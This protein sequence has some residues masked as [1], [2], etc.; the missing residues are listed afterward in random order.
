MGKI[1]DL[2]EIRSNVGRKGREL[3]LI[4]KTTKAGTKN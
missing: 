2:G 4:T 1:W 3:N